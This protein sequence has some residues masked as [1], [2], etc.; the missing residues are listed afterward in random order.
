MAKKAQKSDLPIKHWS[1]SSLMAYLR[2]PLA[3]YKRYVELVYD[4]PSGPSGVI[5]RAAHVALQHYY[6]GIDKEGAIALGMESLRDVADF[7]INFGKAKSKAAKKKKREQMERDYVQAVNFYLEKPP[8]YRKVLGV[9]Y[10]GVAK[11]EGLPLPI[12]AVSDLVVQSAVDPKGVD[13]IDHKFVDTFSSQGAQK[14]LFVMQAIFNYYTVKKNF[15]KPVRRF[16]VI[17][18]KKSRNADG[19]PQLRK[20]IIDFRTFKQ[21]FIIFNRLVRDATATMAV[22]MGMGV[23]LPNPS[24]MFEGENSFD[25]Y[26]INLPPED[27]DSHFRPDK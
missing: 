17:E 25:I 20:Y 15:N 6:G 26:R 13:I 1:H 12:K 21:E 9:E 24:D 10:V 27:Y 3:W 2:N 16:I 23:F 18:C 4:T 22:L 14:T 5:G 8:K 7:E 11:V 19:K